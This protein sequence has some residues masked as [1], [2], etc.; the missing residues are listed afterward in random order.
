MTRKYPD[1]SDLLERKQKAR[2]EKA[3]LSF[4]EK[5][6]LVEKLRERVRPIREAREARQKQNS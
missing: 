5:I 2:R 1:I 4:G 3:A 6:E